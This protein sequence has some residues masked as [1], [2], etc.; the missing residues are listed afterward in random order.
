[1]GPRE[2]IAIR[3]DA[4]RRPRHALADREPDAIGGMAGNTGV[5]RAAG[6]RASI[7]D[8]APTQQHHRRSQCAAV[9]ILV[10]K[11]ELFVLP[12]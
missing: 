8:T 5:C 1:M 3:K 11:R 10:L 7:A 12:V 2:W 9:G 4:H 6:H